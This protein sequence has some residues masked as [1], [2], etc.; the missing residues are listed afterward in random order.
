MDAQTELPPDV[1]ASYGARIKQPESSLPSPRNGRVRVGSNATTTPSARPPWAIRRYVR[2]YLFIH[3]AKRNGWVRALGFYT[4]AW[5]ENRLRQAYRAY[6]FLRWSI[7]RP[8]K[9]DQIILKAM[10]CQTCDQLIV[11]PETGGWYCK[12]CGCRPNPKSDVRRKHQRRW[13][14]VCF[15]G[16]IPGSWRLPW[17]G[18]CKGG[19]CGKG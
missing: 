6:S 13:R 15:M 11:D 19:G 14:G 4:A 3:N 9:P 17:V 5:L 16:R 7:S 10:V 8:E 18:I 12:A 1:L 2:G